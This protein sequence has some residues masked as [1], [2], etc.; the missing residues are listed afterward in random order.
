MRP[1][2]T[3]AVLLRSGD[4]EAV[5][6]GLRTAVSLALGDRPARVFALRPASDAL[7]AATG[8]TADALEA[9]VEAGVAITV[10]AGPPRPG[11]VTQDRAGILAAASSAAFQQVF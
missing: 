8:E 5:L 7:T 4:P 1:A 9:L 3:G 11:V 2:A 6:Q 10:E